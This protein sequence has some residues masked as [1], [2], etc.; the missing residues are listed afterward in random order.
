MSHYSALMCE[1]FKSQET[2]I[3]IKLLLEIY[4]VVIK[5]EILLELIFGNYLLNLNY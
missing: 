3:W 4:I 2:W 5:L 1:E